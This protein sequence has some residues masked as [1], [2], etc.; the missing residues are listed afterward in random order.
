MNDRRINGNDQIETFDQRRRVVEVV[1]FLGPVSDSPWYP[2]LRQFTQPKP[3]DWES[4][5]KEVAGE[6][7]KLV[8]SKALAA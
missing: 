8:S 6:L 5:M 7:Q 1:K 3:N 2:S 4:M